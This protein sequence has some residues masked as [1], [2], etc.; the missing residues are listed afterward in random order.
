[1]LS[2]IQKK[3]K[4]TEDFKFDPSQQDDYETGFLEYRKELFVLYKNIG[5]I[6]PDLMKQF[7]HA[8]TS[9]TISNLNVLGFADAEI[10]LTLLYIT[11]EVFPDMI[12]RPNVNQQ[13]NIFFNLLL[14][15]VGS[16]KFD[17]I[18]TLLMWFKI[19]LTI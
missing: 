3:A 19:I 16:S 18:S 7:I 10:C 8:L 5:I 14:Q 11:A 1:M 4:F 12:N 17:E 6:A 15:I 9:H 13:E 2:T